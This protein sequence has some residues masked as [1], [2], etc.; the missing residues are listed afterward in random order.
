M[1]LARTKKGILSPWHALSQHLSSKPVQCGR[2][3]G[4]DSNKSNLFPFEA[5][6][7]QILQARGDVILYSRKEMSAHLLQQLPAAHD[8]GHRILVSDLHQSYDLWDWGWD[9]RNS[10]SSSTR[11]WYFLVCKKP[12]WRNRVHCFS[13]DMGRTQIAMG[14]RI[15]YLKRSL[16][17]D[18]PT[19]GILRD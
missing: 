4:T 5:A 18:L 16:T 6:L 13:V 12:Y 8:K 3:C 15:V 9:N 2:F 11:L 1:L 17:K 7:R 10:N 19:L 14:R